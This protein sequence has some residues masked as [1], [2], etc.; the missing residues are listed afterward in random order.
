MA[1]IQS[2]ILKLQDA[3]AEAQLVALKPK[4]FVHSMKGLTDCIYLDKATGVHWVK[5]NGDWLD[6]DG[7]LNGPNPTFSGSGTSAV[8][9]ITGMGDVMI[10]TNSVSKVVL[11]GVDVTGS[12]FW[13]DPTSN[14]SL[15]MP[16]HYGRPCIVNN[17][18]A[19][20][21]TFVS[22]GG[23]W[24]IDKVAN[25]DASI[26]KPV[27]GYTA[28]D[29]FRIDPTSDAA[30]RTP[31]SVPGPDGTVF[32]GPHTFETDHGVPFCLASPKEVYYPTTGYGRV[33]RCDYPIAPQLNCSF[34]YLLYFD[35]NVWEAT[36]DLGVKLSGFGAS[37]GHWMIG[38]H[39]GPYY[40]K[41]NPRNHNI[42]ALRDYF[43][44]ADATAGQGAGNGQN[45]PESFG[46]LPCPGFVHIEH[47]VFANTIN[48]DGTS[49]KDGRVQ[50]RINGN[51]VQDIP[52]RWFANSLAR[53][54]KG[55]LQIYH[56]GIASYL[57]KCAYGVG[58]FMA[59]TKLIGI[60]PAFLPLLT[61]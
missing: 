7:V 21:L 16:S 33:A 59:S 41:Q 43:Y 1:D 18:D 8:V 55:T 46:F 53:W 10:Q 56:G 17:T 28:P 39:M 25:K 14:Q 45:S 4:P 20:S 57:K 51:V 36:I 38:E 54:N 60:D 12:C 22:T 42:V 15:T 61:V 32:P 5:T 11:D 3:L 29:L 13:C 52:K 31:G 30:M 58:P 47:T 26:L 6:K 44:D 40:K 37:D 9:D 49:N 24:R 23:N 2:I 50:T 48:A 35:E 27:G 19:K 34:A